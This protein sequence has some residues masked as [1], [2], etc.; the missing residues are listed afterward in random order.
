MTSKIWLWAGLG[1]AVLAGCASEPKDAGFSDVSQA[2]ATRTG[3][4]VLWNR[5]T[6]ED[7][8]AT[9]A[10]QELLKNELTADGAVQVALL[11]N[12]RLQAVFEDLGIAQADL[13]QGGLL[14]NPVLGGHLRFAGN[15][16]TGTN[17]ELSLIQDF[18][19]LALRP[20]KRKVSEA[21]FEQAKLEVSQA[22]MDLAA[23]TK[24]AFYAAQA[25]DQG[26]EMMRTVLQAAEVSK[27][28]AQRLHEAGNTT[29][30]EWASEQATFER[31]RLDLGEAEAASLE[32]RE[33]LISRM[34]LWGPATAFRIAG[35]LP[36]LPEKEVDPAGLEALAV[37]QRL[38]LAAAGK[39]V[40]FQ[41]RRL[42]LTDK[43]R[44]I[45][46][47]NLG[48]DYEKDTDGH[49]VM[50]PALELPLPIFDRGQ[51][52]DQRAQAELAQA[53]ENYYALAVEIRSAA[54]V[55]WNRMRSA[56]ERAEHLHKVAL[57][58]KDRIVRESQLEYNGMLI[59]GFQL[60][61]AKQ[62]E[63]LT[64]HQY[65]EALKAYWLARVDLERAIGG[66][67]TSGEEAPSPP[68]KPAEEAPKDSGHEHH[69]HHE[70]EGEKP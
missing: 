8:Q 26:V 62:E 12:H 59:G 6:P 39:A 63:V 32:A 65:V 42:G 10:V 41:A 23:E 50:G 13:V 38:D 3:Q 30:L 25:A 16:P 4:K 43:Q 60:F 68:D 45:P 52:R 21:A 67:L 17:L 70:H 61:M 54:R 53:R 37:S 35:R 22:V 69:H 34:G 40:E 51:A 24:A 44:L 14:K 64:G 11:N 2:V 33:R 47:L 28:L 46:E 66:R 58:L 57:P 56:R 29:D 49:W 36:G 48:L 27:D 20:L 7:A 1:P 55:A 9:A 19:D 15:D 18:M 5:R 31:V